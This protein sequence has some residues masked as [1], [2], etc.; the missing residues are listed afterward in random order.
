MVGTIQSMMGS[1]IGSGTGQNNNGLPKT[2]DKSKLSNYPEEDDACSHCG[3]KMTKKANKTS[4][5]AFI[6]LLAVDAFTI[7]LILF[8]FSHHHLE[9]KNFGSWPLDG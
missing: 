3:S 4:C 6:F 5:W 9:G 1:V 2:T 8:L 7:G